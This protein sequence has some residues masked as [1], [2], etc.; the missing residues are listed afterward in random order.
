MNRIYKKALGATNHGILIIDEQLKIVFGNT[1]ME[2]LLGIYPDNMIGKSIS[3]ILPKFKDKTL[4]K[5]LHM[6][7]E[8]NQKLFLSAAQHK[9]FALPRNN[10]ENAIRQNLNVVSLE[11]SGRKYALLEI[12]DVTNQFLRVKQLKSYIAKLYELQK[13][14][15]HN[16]LK[17]KTLFD[18]IDVGFIYCEIL[19]DKKGNIDDIVITDANNPFLKTFYKTKES[20][21]G[22]SLVEVGNALQKGFGDRMLSRLARGKNIRYDDI[23]IK[24]FDGYFS[25]TGYVCGGDGYALKIKNITQRKANE[26]TIKKLAYFDQLTG[27]L[28]RNVFEK[29]LERKIQR[30]KRGG[31][32]FTLMFIDIDNFKELNDSFGHDFGDK[33]LVEIAKRLKK[34]TRQGDIVSRFGG[35]EFLILNSDVESVDIGKKIA[36]RILRQL[37]IPLIIGER[38]IRLKV[39]IGI[40][41]CPHD[42]CSKTELLKKADMAMYSAKEVG[43]NKFMFFQ[44]Y[45]KSMEKA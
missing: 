43:G 29:V 7:I 3:E 36:K 31:K 14:L 16:E 13:S 25:V 39:S 33:V 19:W 6:V 23:Y 1:F 32:P 41:I 2:E 18:N 35:D 17:Y 34:T 21:V 44:D 40:S 12:H 30:V 10:C 37:S 45:S 26:R 20:V 8:N 9:Y 22:E 4:Q 11:V 28:S 15:D 42:S 27:L 38:R 24:K 5:I